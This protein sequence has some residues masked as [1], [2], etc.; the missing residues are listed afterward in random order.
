MHIADGILSA[1]VL[2]S[3]AAFSLVGIG[4][5]LQRLDYERIPQVAVLSS[6][7][8]IASLIHLPIGFS[9]I[10]LVLNGLVG[11]ILGWAAFPALAIALFLQAILFGFGGI[12]S[13]GVN[14]FNMAL[15]ALLSFLCF[16]WAIQRTRNET[17]QFLLGFMAGASA[18]ILSTCLISLSLWLSGEGFLP[19]VQLTFIAHIPVMLVEGVIT[20]FIITFLQQVRPELLSAPI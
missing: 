10:H 16:H 3:G 17:W 6:A 2:F 13:L 5:G 11:L 15:P 7:F 4:Y 19:V 9:S 1:P 20:G 14:I 8:F 18:I 12:S